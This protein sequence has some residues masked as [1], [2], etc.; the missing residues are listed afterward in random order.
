VRGNRPPPDSAARTG[1]EVMI[2]LGPDE[3]GFRTATY[4]PPGGPWRGRRPP[5]A[6][7]S[8]RQEAVHWAEH[9]IPAVSRAPAQPACFPLGRPSAW[10]VRARGKRKVI[11]DQTD[12]LRKART[13][14]T[15]ED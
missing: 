3:N 8:R 13:M 2:D 4:G 9:E 5:E 12:G 10:P 11:R 15:D 1:R 7:R 14:T 6:P